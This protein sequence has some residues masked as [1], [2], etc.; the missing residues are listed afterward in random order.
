MNAIEQAISELVRRGDI[1]NI[2]LV[3]WAVCMT[4]MAMLLLRALMLANRNL[5]RAAADIADAQDHAREFVRE[6]SAFNRAHGVE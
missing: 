2:A 4:I 5:A 1:A 6:L 3:L